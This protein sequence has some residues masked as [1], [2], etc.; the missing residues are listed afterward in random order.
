MAQG[1]TPQKNG[2]NLMI[3]V[4]VFFGIL[5]VFQSGPF[6]MEKG[7]NDFLTDLNI[8]L[9]RDQESYRPRINKL[10]SKMDRMQKGEGNRY[11]T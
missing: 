9:R 1:Q 3:W 6:Q 8:T 4:L 2:K 11:Y 7:M 5:Y 10:D